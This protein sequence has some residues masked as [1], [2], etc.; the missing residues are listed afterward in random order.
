MGGY[1]SKGAKHLPHGTRVWPCAWAATTS[2]SSC[3]NVSTDGQCE[4][5]LACHVVQAGP[6]LTTVGSALGMTL[7]RFFASHTSLQGSVGKQEKIGPSP[8]CSM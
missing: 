7:K 6:L 8:K 5:Q 1:E 4:Y 3:S 2:S